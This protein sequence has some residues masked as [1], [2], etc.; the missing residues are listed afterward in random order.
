MIAVPHF[1]VT[2]I[3]LMMSIIINSNWASDERINGTLV[4]DINML[5]VL[6]PSKL[7]IFVKMALNTK[8]QIKSKICG[9]CLPLFCYFGSSYISPHGVV[10][11]ISILLFMILPTQQLFMILPT[12]QLFNEVRVTNQ[13][14]EP[15]CIYVLEV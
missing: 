8:N 6:I 9:G 13:E 11:P 14:N 2:V 5:S 15:S 4:S 7:G 10:L 3:S 1:T 12:Q